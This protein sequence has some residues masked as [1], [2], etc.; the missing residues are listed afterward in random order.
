MSVLAWIVLGLVSG[1]IAS[2]IV[3]QT[4]GGILVDIV[5]GIGGAILGGWMFT[6]VGHTGVTGLNLS[7]VF[8]SIVG[9]V[10]LISIYNLIYN[11]RHR[12]A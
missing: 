11:A 8:V 3:G 12:R 10:A 9:A 6:S 1:Y 4:G 7:S 5:V 2:L